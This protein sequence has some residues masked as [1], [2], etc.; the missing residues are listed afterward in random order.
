MEDAEPVKVIQVLVPEDLRDLYNTPTKGVAAFYV[1][2]REVRSLIERIAILEHQL[3]EECKRHEDRIR[4]CEQLE[5]ELAE[6]RAR[7]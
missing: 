5:K 7:T 1:P 3:S 2:A 6:L 4:Q